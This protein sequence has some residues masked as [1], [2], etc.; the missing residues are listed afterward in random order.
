MSFFVKL[1]KPKK[2]KKTKTR[3][4][5]VNNSK[6]ITIF[7]NILSSFSLELTLQCNT[8]IDTCIFCNKSFQLLSFLSTLHICS[9]FHRSFL[10]IFFN[11]PYPLPN[12]CVAFSSNS[13]QPEFVTYG[14][15]YGPKYLYTNHAAPRKGI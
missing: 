3:R 2:N 14:I 9:H 11:L 10:F 13:H 12:T 6:I 5:S 8:R 15:K 4:P 7:L 1:K